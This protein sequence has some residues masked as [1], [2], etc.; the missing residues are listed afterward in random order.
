MF[1]FVSP[2]FCSLCS[3]QSLV[4]SIPSVPSVLFNP[5]FPFNTRRG[6]GGFRATSVA[7]GSRRRKRCPKGLGPKKQRA[8]GNRWFWLRSKGTLR[9]A[10][11]LKGTLKG[12]KDV[13]SFR[14]R[15]G[16][17]SYLKVQGLVGD[18]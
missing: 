2:I 12:F 14:P 5:L 3:V 10:G 15:G 1:Y 16:S 11:T 8:E 18:L 13:L 6:S 17:Q 9:G 7:G 4:P